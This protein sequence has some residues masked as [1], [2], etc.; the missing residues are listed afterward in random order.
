MDEAARSIKK[1]KN[2]VGFGTV[3]VLD[4]PQVIVPQALGA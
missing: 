2:L 4:G 3:A 1:T